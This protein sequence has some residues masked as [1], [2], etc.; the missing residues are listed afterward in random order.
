MRYSNF[1][2]A[3][4]LSC[5]N[6]PWFYNPLS[7]E[8]LEICLQT[9]PQSRKCTVQTRDSE[10]VLKYMWRQNMCLNI[11]TTQHIPTITIAVLT[12]HALL[13]Q[14]LKS[15]AVWVPLKST[16]ISPLASRDS[17]FYLLYMMKSQD[18][19]AWQGFHIQWKNGVIW[20]QIMIS[21]EEQWQNTPLSK[22]RWKEY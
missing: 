17:G 12:T 3:I 2:A 21:H 19:I 15:F 22:S 10:E 4:L 9:H 1:F 8:K 7:H 11:S 20:L 18:H 16:R 13:E 5:F 14:T 6:Q